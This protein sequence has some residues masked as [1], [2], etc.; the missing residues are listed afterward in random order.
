M[1]CC[2]TCAG[3]RPDQGSPASRAPRWRGSAL[4]LRWPRAK[5]FPSVLLGLHWGSSH[6]GD[7]P[8]RQFVMYSLRS[9]EGSASFS[10]HLGHLWRIPL[11]PRGSSRRAL[12]R[13]FFRFTNSCLTSTSL[14]RREAPWTTSCSSSPVMAVLLLAQGL[15]PLSLTHRRTPHLGAPPS[16]LRH[17]I[18]CLCRAG[19]SPPW[20]LPL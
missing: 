5:T 17:P 11:P 16:A 13:H 18:P 9:G 8:A 6:S 12:Q 15:E 7:C 20:L 3:G 14:F 10:G 1:A 2:C 19:Q 4:A